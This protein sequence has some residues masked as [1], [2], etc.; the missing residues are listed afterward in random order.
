MEVPW[1]KYPELERGSIGWRMGYGETYMNEWV[2][3]FYALSRKE[4]VAH[5][6]EATPLPM[7]W[8]RWVDSCLFEEGYND[9]YGVSAQRMEDLGLIEKA[10]DL[11]QWEK[12]E[13]ER[14]KAELGLEDEDSNG[15]LKGPPQRLDGNRLCLAGCGYGSGNPS[16]FG[17]WALGKRQRTVLE[18]SLSQCLGLQNP[19]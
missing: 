15:H 13:Y 8:V 16:A 3:W 14:L 1:K 4:Q 11:I 19:A 12:D 7:E 10:E 6:K 5:F 9:P 18:S 2:D 17:K